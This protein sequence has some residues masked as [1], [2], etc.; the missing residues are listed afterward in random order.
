[1]EPDADLIMASARK[2]QDHYGLVATLANCLR[3]QGSLGKRTQQLSL[4]FGEID[5]V[6]PILGLQHNDLSVVKGLDI[7]TWLGR[8]HR[9]GGARRSCPRQMP[10]IA[11]NEASLSEKRCFAFGYFFPVNSKKSDAGIRHRFDFSKL[12]PSL[13][14]LNTG[15]P[16]GPDGGKLKFIGTSSMPLPAARI[17]GPRSFILMSSATGRSSSLCCVGIPNSNACIMSQYCF[18]RMCCS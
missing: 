7:G 14:K 8:K 1:M 2:P 6:R 12:R 16:R 4:W 5:P 18:Q 13:R 9:E 11:K 10:A 17:T 15:P 3:V